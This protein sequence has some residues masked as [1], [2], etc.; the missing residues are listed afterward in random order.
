M[1]VNIEGVSVAAQI[2]FRFNWLFS[3]PFLTAA[4]FDSGGGVRG[5]VL[6]SLSSNETGQG[7]FKN[8][9]IPEKKQFDDLYL[10]YY[11]LRSYL[12]RTLA[13]AL[14]CWH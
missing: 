9:S 7:A 5:H 2:A 6:T 11:A 3:D 4:M 13:L 14:F 8:R 10:L 1:H 12:T